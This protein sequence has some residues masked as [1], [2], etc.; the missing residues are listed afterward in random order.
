MAYAN[1]VAATEPVTIVAAEGALYMRMPEFIAVIYVRS[2]MIVE[3]FASAFYPVVKTLALH[4]LEF[5]RWRVPSSAGTILVGTR[6]RTLLRLGLNSLRCEEK[7]GG[8]HSNVQNFLGVQW[9]PLSGDFA[10]TF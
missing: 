7:T 9:V 5:G 3:I 2:T 4:L 10:T 6:R 1:V 8:E